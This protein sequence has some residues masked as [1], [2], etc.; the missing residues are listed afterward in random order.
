MHV[1]TVNAGS[2]SLKLAAVDG[3]TVVAT[4]TSLDNALAGDRP[5]AVAHRVVHGGGRSVATVVDDEVLE[6]LRALT[7]LAPLHQ[8]PAL[9]AIDACR[10]RWPTVPNVACFDTA[11]HATVPE[12]A[13]TYALPA[14][15]RTVV[16]AYGFH[17][18]SYAWASAR[19]RVLAPDARRVLIAH[20]G[21]G[22]SLCAVLNG[23]SVATTMGFTPLDGLVMA[24][25]CGA[26][27]P[28]A[29]LWLE[30]HL[31]DGDDLEAVLETESGLLGLCG[32]A[33][34]REL[35]SRVAAR[36]RDAELAFEVWRH[37]A[38][39]RAGAC[40]A[41][42]GGLD[43]IVFTGGIGEHDAVARAALIEGLA[44]LGAAAVAG[45]DHAGEREITA[46][47]SSIRCF[48]VPAREELQLATEAHACLH[49]AS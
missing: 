42:M 38:I 7:D 35:H 47:G 17:G 41:A 24:T 15:Y 34:M 19:A 45:P 39:E 44:W 49:A 9:R 36:D 37:R 33:E 3:D 40:I 28:G 48:V 8:P 46:A 4:P 10:A 1:L 16:R 27:D 29:V 31:V 32:T 13:R 26:L 25:R 6:E 22:Q 30:R 21:G 2:T 20:L 12:A 23:R 5:D 11:F 14:R 43:A 18:L